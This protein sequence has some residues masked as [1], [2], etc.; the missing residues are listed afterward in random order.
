M[1]I[2][3]AEIKVARQLHKKGKMTTTA[4]MIASINAFIVDWVASRI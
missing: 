2:A 3:K 1:G 4:R